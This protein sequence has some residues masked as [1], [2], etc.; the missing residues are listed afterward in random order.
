MPAARLDVLR[1]VFSSLRFFVLIEKTKLDAEY[2]RG[3][4][5]ADC[6]PALAAGQELGSPSRAVVFV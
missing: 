1:K 6:F 3:L 5:A 4:R 2:I